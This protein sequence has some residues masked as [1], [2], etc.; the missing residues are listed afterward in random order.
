MLQLILRKSDNGA[1]SSELTRLSA[2]GSVALPGRNAPGS[3]MGYLGTK[4]AEKLGQGA[5][6]V[7]QIQ[8]KGPGFSASRIQLFL[9]QERWRNSNLRTAVAS[10]FFLREV[11][12]DCD[13]L[14]QYASRSHKPSIQYSAFRQLVALCTRYPGLSTQFLHSKYFDTT[15]ESKRREQIFSAWNRPDDPSCTKFN[16]WHFFCELAAELVADTAAFLPIDSY[17]T[18]EPAF[19]TLEVEG[20]GVVERLLNMSSPDT[21]T[22]FP[23]HI[24]I[25]YL[26]TLLSRDI[27]WSPPESE[28]DQSPPKSIDK[29]LSRA[30]LLLQDLGL[31]SNADSGSRPVPILVLDNEGVDKFCAVLLSGLDDSFLSKLRAAGC[32]VDIT[33]EPWYGNLEIIIELL[34][35]V[36]AESIVPKSAVIAMN[37]NYQYHFLC[38]LEERSE[39]VPSE[40]STSSDGKD[41]NDE[42]KNVQAVSEPEP[43]SLLHIPDIVGSVPA[44]AL[45]T[46]AS[47]TSATDNEAGA[48]ASFPSTEPIE[49]VIDPSALPV[50]P[51]DFE[52]FFSANKAMLSTVGSKGDIAHLADT[53]AVVFKGLDL[54]ARVHPFI[55]VPVMVFKAVLWL[56]LAQRPLTVDPKIIAADF[57]MQNMMMSLFSLGHIKVSDIAET[58]LQGRLEELMRTISKDITSFGNMCDVYSKKSLIV[59]TLKARIYEARLA[60]FVTQ[61]NNRKMEIEFALQLHTTHR[62]EV[63]E[64]GI[65]AIANNIEGVFRNLETPPEKQMRGLVEKKGGLREYIERDGTLAA[66]ISEYIESGGTLAG[67][68]PPNNRAESEVGGEGGGRIDMAREEKMLR[69]ELAEDVDESFRNNVSEFNQKLELQA[70]VG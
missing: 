32:S 57:Q 15:A 65:G 68:R 23:S 42:A 11:A 14:I 1:P 39:Y 66:L 58:T 43:A 30:K 17:S 37:T 34:R 24:A 49:T 13:Q 31:N 48:A 18:L 27:F 52:S 69:E 22:S 21:S 5:R 55:A 2:P 40:H 61:F 47:A 60:D 67:L 35:G 16:H 28:P 54:L 38:T 46:P 7:A 8:Q 53:S 51:S 44:A 3:T 9:D 10:D 33:S 26:G 56:H 50:E 45:E 25:R 12:K 6:K 59:R 70:R 64:Q 41:D 36:N 20:T 4:I 63:L 29:L 62:L 19:F